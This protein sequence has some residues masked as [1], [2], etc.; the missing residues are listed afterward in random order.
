M[1]TNGCDSETLGSLLQH[2]R[3]EIK[4]TVKDGKMYDRDVFYVFETVFF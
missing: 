4:E 2:V 1:T 3:L